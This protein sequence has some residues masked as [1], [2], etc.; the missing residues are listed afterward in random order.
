MA[1]SSSPAAS[2]RRRDSLPARHPAPPGQRRHSPSADFHRT[3]GSRTTSSTSTSSSAKRW[4]SRHSAVQD[5]QQP[6]SVARELKHGLQL[7][8]DFRVTEH[9]AYNFNWLLKIDGDFRSLSFQ[10]TRTARSLKSAQRA[11]EPFA[12][13]QSATT[14]SPASLLATSRPKGSPKSETH[15]RFEICGEPAIMGPIDAL[16]RLSS[17][18]A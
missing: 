7:V 5:H 10:R 9:D 18:S 16:L 14:F 4:A 3:E 17:H 6:G 8:R 11:A 2:E 15:G 12:R 13:R 1:S